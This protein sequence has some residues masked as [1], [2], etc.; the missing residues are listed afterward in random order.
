MKKNILKKTKSHWFAS[1]MD[2]SN[3]ALDALVDY[4]GYTHPGGTG[5][6]GEQHAQPHHDHGIRMM[7][8][9]PTSSPPQNTLPAPSSSLQISQQR[10]EAAAAAVAFMEASQRAA[11]RAR[12]AAGVPDGGGGGGGGGGSS[13]GGGV[14]ESWGAIMNREENN[15]SLQERQKKMMMAP[16]PHRAEGV[17][18]SMRAMPDG[19]AGQNSEPKHMHPHHLLQQQ[20]QHAEQH[21]QERGGGFSHKQQDYDYQQHQELHR[22]APQL[23]HSAVLPQQPQLAEAPL[24]PATPS[25]Q[26]QHWGQTSLNATGTYERTPILVPQQQQQQQQDLYQQQ[27]QGYQS[28]V[29]GRADFKA[30][31]LG[32]HAVTS[33]G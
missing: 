22:Q 30:A 16:P 29:S 20:Q 32:A 27:Q 2:V 10:I 15:F 7:G 6:R 8:A 24:P 13:G 14:T 23:A 9:P 28:D 1:I 3:S 31:G 5:M 25:Q 17:G 19:K 33:V 12:G 26:S 18:G 21:V 4:S 11:M